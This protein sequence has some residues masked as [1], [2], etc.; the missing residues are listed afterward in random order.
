V[1]TTASFHNPFISQPLHLPMAN[2][3]YYG[4]GGQQYYPPQG[5]STIG[6]SA[7]FRV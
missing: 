1:N 5:W 7:E 6:E 3:D 4:G 2:K